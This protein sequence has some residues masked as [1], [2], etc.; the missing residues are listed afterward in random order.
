[1]E[2]TRGLDVMWRHSTSTK[3]KGVQF[4]NIRCV[5]TWLT[6]LMY[7]TTTFTPQCNSIILTKQLINSQC[8]KEVCL[9]EPVHQYQVL[10]LRQGDLFDFAQTYINDMRLFGVHLPSCQNKNSSYTS[11]PP[12]LIYTVLGSYN[13]YN[14]DSS[15][16]QRR[17][18]TIHLW[19]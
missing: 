5:I 10:S 17:P 16:T 11:K 1:M 12:H 3:R 19:F 7:D 4:V 18:W 6:C 15:L 8:S 9:N 2:F 13:V 14:G